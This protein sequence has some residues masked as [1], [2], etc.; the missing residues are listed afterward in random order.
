M[1][2]GYKEMRKDGL[3]NEPSPLSENAM[4]ALLADSR[5]PSKMRIKEITF[6]EA[7]KRVM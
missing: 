1:P 7:F 2:P 5:K 4:E 6:K 3:E